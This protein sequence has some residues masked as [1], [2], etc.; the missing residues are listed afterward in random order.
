VNRPLAIDLFCGLGGW[1]EGLLAEGYDVIGFDIERHEYGEHKYPG[2]LVIQD[3]RTLHGSQFKDAALIVASPP[4][5]EY[6]YMA[7]PWSRAKAIADDYRS[8]KRDT[9]QLTALFDACFR[10]QREACEAAGRHI[11]MVVENVRGARPWVGPA[12]GHFGSF[13]LWGDVPA[14]MPVGRNG[15]AKGFPHRTAGHWTNPAEHEGTKLRDLD[16]YERQ[17][18]DPFGWRSPRTS[19]S[20]TKAR[21]QASAMIAKIPAPLA[22]HIA[23]MFY[24]VTEGTTMNITDYTASADEI[25]HRAVDVLPSLSN[26]DPKVAAAAAA[27]EL[28]QN[29]LAGALEEAICAAI[30]SVTAVDGDREEL[31]DA[32]QHLIEDAVLADPLVAG[33]IQ[34]GEPLPEM[35][36]LVT[37]VAMDSPGMAGAVAEAIAARIAPKWAPHHLHRGK[38]LAKLGVVAEHLERIGADIAPGSVYE[39]EAEDLNGAWRAAYQ[40]TFGE[41]SAESF[42][43]A[44]PIDPAAWNNLTVAPTPDLQPQGPPSTDDLR[45]GYSDLDSVLFGRP[46][47][48]VELLGISKMTW[49]NW[50][51]HGRG[52][53]K[54]TPAQA[55]TLLA[56]IDGTRMMLGRAELIFSRCR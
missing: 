28:A 49:D 27:I 23:K 47:N 40:G 33:A 43:E 26:K 2:A 1:A 20:A 24:P 32:F 5:Q 56:L 11:P 12:Q 17:H 30:D 54:C 29:R 19:S 21:K 44:A 18:P 52:K 22:E 25:V 42:S 14:L 15:G 35:Y 41:G 45:Q 36:S 13:Y 51:R 16:G 6:S 8:G 7:M 10:I 9:K 34:A 55:A 46:D 48:L 39:G 3:V 53:P 31:G 4:C 50:S 38:W 37:G